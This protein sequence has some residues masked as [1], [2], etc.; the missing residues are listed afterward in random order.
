MQARLPA[1]VPRYLA[2]QGA[3]GVLIG[4]LFAL[5]VLACDVGGLRTLVAASGDPVVAAV[6]VGGSVMAILP[7]AFATAIA[8]L[9]KG[10]PALGRPA[11]ARAPAPARPPRAGTVN[12]SRRRTP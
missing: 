8:L 7:L 5:L 6:F 1:S 9:P 3:A 11:L 10:D 2:V 4:L 12:D